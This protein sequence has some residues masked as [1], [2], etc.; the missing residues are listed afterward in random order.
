M[1][2]SESRRRL[3]QA[4]SIQDERQLV[5]QYDAWASDYDADLA[6]CGYRMPPVIAG[7][8]VRRL[9]DLKAPIL[10][11]GSG[12]GILGEALHVLGYSEITAIDLSVGML[13]V[14]AGKGIYRATRQMVLGEPLDFPDGCF[15]GVVAMGVLT[16]GHAPPS[17]LDEM[18]RITKPGGVII[19]SMLHQDP[20]ETRFRT[21]QEDLERR[22]LWSLVEDTPYFQS[23]PYGEPEVSHKA[24]VYRVL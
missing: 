11:A 5:E 18:V 15:A 2:I 6:S 1:E 12:T 10:D 23:L 21:K 7:L 16:V 24:Y 13:R 9:P 8:V 3:A 14:A 22:E 4:Y 20:V 19:F 17:S